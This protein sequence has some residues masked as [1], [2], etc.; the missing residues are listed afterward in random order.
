[1]SLKNVDYLIVGF[2]IAGAALA[3]QLRKR[4]QKVVVYDR[5]F[6][7]QAS[8]VAAGLF[9]PVTGKLLTKT[10]NADKLF[11]Y[12]H[13]FY[14]EAEEITG[15]KFFHPKN[16][17]IPFGS[18]LEQNNFMV[19]EGLKDFVEEIYTSRRFSD[20]IYDDF[21]GVIL[22]KSG[23][24]DTIKYLDA[25][26]K[27]LASEGSYEEH[28]FIHNDLLVHGDHVSYRGVSA[29]AV[30]FCEGRRVRDNPWFSWVPIKPLK[31]ETIEI[32][33]RR[34]T[35]H[36]FNRGVYVVQSPSAPV[37][38]AQF[39]GITYKV[40]ATYSH[41]ISEG[42]TIAGKNELKE[43]LLALFRTNF[44]VGHQTWGIRPTTPDRRPLAGNHPDHENLLIFNGMGTKGVSLAPYY[45][46]VL[47][48]HILGTSNI[49][50][51]VNISRFYALY[52][53]F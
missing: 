26:S 20:M 21:G 29:K 14:R 46:A 3:L 4:G 15:E 28:D 41:D 25:V 7:N 27:L 38:P 33:L 34:E 32:Q 11:S 19:K 10:W 18:A 45:S 35:P 22:K 1:L 31:G 39:P 9:N 44:R 24:I 23:F 16:I 52:S 12:L 51:E 53:K 36:I 49:E 2:G 40:G 6:E 30:V 50:S 47:S 42:A 5:P 37:L 8:R 17:C 43:K 13:G 48:E